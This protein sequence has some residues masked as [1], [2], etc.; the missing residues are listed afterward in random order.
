[1]SE[2]YLPIID[3]DFE[4]GHAHI[5]TNGTLFNL[6]YL[7]GINEW[8]ESYPA[9]SVALMRLAVLTECDDKGT[10]MFQHNHLTFSDHATEFIYREVI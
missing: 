6:C 5:E 10:L 8:S 4:S 9:L 7:E 2:Q 1:M 3:Y